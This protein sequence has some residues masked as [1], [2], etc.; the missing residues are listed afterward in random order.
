[1][2]PVVVRPASKGDLQPVAALH[3]AQ[4]GDHFLGKFSVPLLARFYKAF[5]G[6]AIFLVA[7]SQGN[8]SGFVLGGLDSH[9]GFQKKNFI[10]DNF[11][12]IVLEALVRPGI[13]GM[14]ISRVFDFG[15]GSPQSRSKYQMRLLSIAVDDDSKGKGVSKALVSG[16]ESSL[17]DFQTYGLS[18]LAENARAVAF[19]RKLGYSE[20]FVRGVSVYF[21][22]SI[23]KDHSDSRKTS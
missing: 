11:L 1:M 17:G 13:W 14:V 19:Y 10:K 12:R 2:N 20:E 15:F 4:F 8:V 16:F 3:K 5:L 6:K 9:M 22:K 23:E 7:I 18:V 21:F